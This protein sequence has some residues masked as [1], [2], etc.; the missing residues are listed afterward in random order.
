LSGFFTLQIFSQL[1]FAQVGAKAAG[2]MGMSLQIFTALNGLFI[3]LLTARTPVFTRLVALGRRDELRRR[4]KE[5]FLQSV[6]LLLI[7]IM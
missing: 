7:A 3:V 4:F 2:S 5:A 1:L 6:V